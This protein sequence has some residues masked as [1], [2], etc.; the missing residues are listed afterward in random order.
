MLFAVLFTDRPNQGDV[1]AA[2]LQAHIAW[3]EQHKTKPWNPALVQ[4][5]CRSQGAHL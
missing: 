5:Q 2:H 3:L 1:R 4:S